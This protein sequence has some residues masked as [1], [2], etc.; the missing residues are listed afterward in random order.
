MSPSFLAAMSPSFL[1]AISFPAV[2]C[3]S[4]CYSQ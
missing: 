2:G 1:A 3:R 4:S